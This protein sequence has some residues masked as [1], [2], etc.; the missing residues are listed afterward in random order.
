MINE[1]TPFICSVKSVYIG[2]TDSPHNTP[3]EQLDRFQQH[4]APNIFTNAK[5]KAFF[6]KWLTIWHSQLVR[7]EQFLADFELTKLCFLLPNAMLPNAY[8]CLVHK[9]GW[10]WSAKKSET[11]EI[12]VIMFPPIVSTYTYSILN[13]NTKNEEEKSFFN[14]ICLDI[15]ESTVAL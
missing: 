11:I 8:F 15:Q 1:W 10:N 7:T 3:S 6:G 4:F 5:W 14:P 2:F 12:P 9:C 13:V